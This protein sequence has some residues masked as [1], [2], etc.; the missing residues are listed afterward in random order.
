MFILRII[1]EKNDKNLN[2]PLRVEKFKK[3]MKIQNI[4]IQ[5]LFKK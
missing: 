4:N 5:F 3:L 1:L 2:N